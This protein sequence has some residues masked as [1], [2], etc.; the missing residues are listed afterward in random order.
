[1]RSA[2]IGGAS[3]KLGTPAPQVRARGAAACY[4]EA[5]VELVLS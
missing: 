5:D 3:F 4:G 1:M 2:L